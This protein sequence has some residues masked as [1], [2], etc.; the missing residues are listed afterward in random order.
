MKAHIEWRV[1]GISKKIPSYDFTRN[2][3]LPAFPTPGMGIV[4]N[5]DYCAEIT[6]RPQDGDYLE[7]NTV[8]KELGILIITRSSDWPDIESFIQSNV[9]P[10]WKWRDEYD[11]EHVTGEKIFGDRS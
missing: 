10:G 7:Y 11:N 3:E 4:V 1:Y 5:E 8:T 6:F 9:G 2:I